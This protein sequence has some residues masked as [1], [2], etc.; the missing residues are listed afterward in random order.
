MLLNKA[1]SVFGHILFSNRKERVHDLQ[2]RFIFYESVDV[3]EHGRF[4]ADLHVPPDDVKALL[5]RQ[6]FIHIS[7]ILL[8]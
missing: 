5:Y 7:D 2:H 4:P 8:K 3:V 1:F 6:D